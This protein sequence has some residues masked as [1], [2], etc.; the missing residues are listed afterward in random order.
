MIPFHDPFTGT[1]LREA[2]GP[3]ALAGEIGERSDPG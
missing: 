2:A 1:E 3:E